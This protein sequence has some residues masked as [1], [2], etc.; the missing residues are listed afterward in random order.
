MKDVGAWLAGEEGEGRNSL[1]IDI[2]LMFAPKVVYWAI[3]GLAR[4]VD[5]GQW[6]MTGSIEGAFCELPTLIIMLFV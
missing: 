6:M 4:M 3:I 2:W 1:Y 5:N